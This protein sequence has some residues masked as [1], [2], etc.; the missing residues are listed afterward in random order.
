MEEQENVKIPEVVSVG[1]FADK[2]GIPVSQV[3]TELIKNGVMATINENIDYETAEI[4]AEFLGQKIE[5]ES[6]PSRQA[7]LDD[8]RDKE[9]ETGKKPEGK[10]LKPRPPVVAVLGHVDHGKT[11][12][13]DAIRET[14]VVAGESGGITQHIGAYQVDMGGLSTPLGIKK[15]TFLDTPG[16][17]AFE[18]MRAHGAQITDIAIIVVAADDGIKPQTTEAI[19]HVKEA[20]T[21]MIVAINK[22][23]KP[24]ADPM[25]VKKQFAEIG[26]N[27]QE[28]GGDTEFVEIS[29]KEKKGID[30]LLET[31]IAMAELLDLKA[32]PTVPATGVVIEAKMVVGKGAMP[33]VLIQNGTLHVGDFVVVGENY[34]KIRSMEDEH[35]KKKKE[36][37]PGTPVRIT[38]LKD[39][40]KTS[41]ILGVCADEKEAKTQAGK[42]QK[43]AHVKKIKSLTK[44]SLEALSES[45]SRAEKKELNIVIKADVSGTLDAI[46]SSIE[47]VAPKEVMVKFVGEGVGDISENDVS[48]ADVSDKVVVGF[49][50]GVGSGVDGIAKSQGVKI[51]KYDVIYELID[52]VKKLLSDLMPVERKEIPVGKLKVLAIFKVSPKKSVVGGKI[53][54]G[55]V[56]KDVEARVKRAKEV[57]AEYHVSSVHKEKEEVSSMPEGSECGVGFDKKVDIAEGD[58][59]E[60]YRVEE[61]KKSL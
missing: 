23:D 32:D 43:Y 8:A 33:S 35:L 58:V 29:A 25:R 31:V 27:P 52:D 37:L 26:I 44:D 9:K 1:E 7:G 59:L 5:P 51:L 22:I 41:E 28:W 48:M 45:F 57:V 50:V 56:E 12:L 4:I 11:K 49:K 3:I 46:K 34:G 54:E 14:D 21:Q 53:E 30:K 47:K 6:L 55:K 36:A 16:H 60:F 17:E 42:S 18:A 19:K 61:H 13:L 20:G 24:G 38:G 15:I 40:P 10:N 2:L 39:M